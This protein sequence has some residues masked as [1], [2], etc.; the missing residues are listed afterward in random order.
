MKS[1]LHTA[2]AKVPPVPATRHM[3]KRK[4]SSA[5]EP[6][7]VAP[8]RQPMSDE[9]QAMCMRGSRFG[10]ISSNGYTHA[11]T[12]THTHLRVIIIIIIG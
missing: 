2:A 7:T 12:H 4:T 9:E 11:H 5:S 6:I 10:T 1:A 3:M 8:S